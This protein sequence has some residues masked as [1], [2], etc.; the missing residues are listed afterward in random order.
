MA[1]NETVDTQDDGWAAATGLGFAPD[2]D[3]WHA[4]D[5]GAAD[6]AATMDFPSAGE[7]LSA[8]ASLTPNVVE[9]A[10][11]SAGEEGWLSVAD[12]RLDLD[13]A[14]KAMVEAADPAGEASHEPAAGGYSVTET[15]PVSVPVDETSFS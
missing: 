12:D 4:L 2:A 5:A 3:G 7:M 14:L 6:M 15:G 1:I 11:G 10:I 13:R 8:A 9:R